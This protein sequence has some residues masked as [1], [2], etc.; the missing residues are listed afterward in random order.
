[1]TR[2]R[3]VT[4]LSLSLSVSAAAHTSQLTEGVPCTGADH[5]GDVSG[6]EPQPEGGFVRKLLWLLCEV[7]KPVLPAAENVDHGLQ[8]EQDH[9][10][11]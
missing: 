6:S 9:K 11:R 4:A 8:E 5:P 7:C 1:M 10:L 3:R 2:V